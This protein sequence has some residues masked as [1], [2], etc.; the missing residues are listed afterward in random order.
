MVGTGIAGSILAAESNGTLN[1]GGFQQE[2]QL[3]S[4]PPANNNQGGSL[5]NLLGAT[6]GN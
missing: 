4:A 5:P 3:S 2:R 6:G 1:L